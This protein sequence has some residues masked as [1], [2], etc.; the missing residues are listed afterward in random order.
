[1]SSTKSEKNK[2]KITLASGG[3]VLVLL[4]FPLLAWTYLGP[5]QY[6]FSGVGYGAAWLAVLMVAGLTAWITKRE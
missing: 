3:G 1:M 2:E 6:Q 4:G 5:D